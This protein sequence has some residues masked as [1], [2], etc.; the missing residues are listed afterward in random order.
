MKPCHEPIK[1]AKA[2]GSER[3]MEVIDSSVKLS[4]E[5]NCEFTPCLSKYNKDVTEPVTEEQPTSDSSNQDEQSSVKVLG[6]AWNT[7]SDEF[8]YRFW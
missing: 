3:N 5:S 4:E 7:E 1:T 6:M 8:E 2:L